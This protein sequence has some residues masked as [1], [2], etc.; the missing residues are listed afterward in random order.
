VLGAHVDADGRIVK[1]QGKDKEKK[2]T[3]V[4]KT[5]VS[6]PHLKSLHLDLLTP[7]HGP[8]LKKAQV[9][10]KLPYA[11]YPT[12]KKRLVALRGRTTLTSLDL[13]NTSI[14]TWDG[15]DDL[16][17]LAPGD[18]GALDSSDVAELVAAI[19]ANPN[20]RE[21]T[22]PHAVVDARE[23]RTRTSEEMAA[24]ILDGITH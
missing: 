9:L 6:L 14:P 5:I 2:A 24:I 15:A 8:L 22:F 3:D 17:L 21:I 1:D 23:L 18:P 16:Q 19:E 13:G 7:K 20:L 4:V 12:P 11:V 10:E